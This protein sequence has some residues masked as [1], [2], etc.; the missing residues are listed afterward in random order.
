MHGHR[1][2]VSTLGGIVA[3]AHPHAARAGAR[4]LDQGGN[5]FDAV[6]ATAAALNVV[7]PYMS[8]FGGMGLATCWVAAEQRTR[9]LNFVPPLPSQF[10]VERYAKRE[11]LQRGAHSV[12]T[13]GNLAGWAELHRRYGKLKFGECFASAI[14]LARDGYPVTEFN[15]EETNLT[16]PELKRF[17]ELYPPWAQHYTDGSGQLRLGWVLRQ[18]DLANTFEAIAA[19][20]PGLLYGGALGRRV[21]AHLAAQGGTLTMADLE[22]MN[23]STA[24][25][26]SDAATAR[27]RHL[28]VHTPPPPCEG[29]QMLLA[30]RLLDGVDL[31]RLQNNGLE[32]LDL[33]LR[34]VRLAAGVRIDNN[35]PAPDRLAELL[36]DAHVAQLRA[37]LADGKPVQGP[38][39]QWLAPSPGR[40][41]GEQHTTSFSIADADGNLVCVTQSIGSPFGS[42]VIVP[43]TGLTLNN[44]LYWADVQPG[45]P[46]R[47]KPGAHLPICMAPSLSLA[48]G[49]PVLALGTP[50][51]YGILQTQV[52][53][54]VQHVDFGHA[55]QSAIEQP[56]CRLLDGTTVHVE[57]RI[58]P[59]VVSALRYRGH[60]VVPAEP[61]TMLVGGMHGI[62]IDPT[63]GVKTGGADPRRDGYVIPA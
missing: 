2:T 26:W 63:T 52:Q 44:F 48:D 32:H 20:G 62:S 31:A 15:V 29:F 43:G 22:A 17:D 28:T 19:E 35:N 58:R 46:N 10:P 1:P 47:S 57:T 25:V 34:A 24:P 6:V 37:R 61:W 53:A 5:A 45:S 13:P 50:G 9:T 49:K 59:E 23:G 42:G 54:L 27:Y 36:S 60:G 41:G 55:V 40:R 21:I 56:R 7:E 14:A 4:V 39:E 38:T 12:G 33:V 11:D 16:G 3:A 8:S 30:L 51:S 18:P